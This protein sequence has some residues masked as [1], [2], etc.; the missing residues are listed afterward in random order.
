MHERLKHIKDCLI[1]EIEKQMHCL[2]KVNAQELGEVFDMVKDA[3][4]AL[5]YHTITEAML[6][7]DKT[8]NFSNEQHKYYM[9]PYYNLRMKPMTEYLYETETPY[10]ERD[11]REGSS[12]LKRKAYLE[13]KEMKKDK[14]TQLKELEKYMQELTSDIVEMI[15]DATV[16]EKQY[17]EKKISALASKIGQMK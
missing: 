9:E 14:T 1:C 5:Y 10:R 11:Y 3:E 15:Q 4:E 16:E 13:S 6:E 2:D 12:P 7:G 17:L 8:E